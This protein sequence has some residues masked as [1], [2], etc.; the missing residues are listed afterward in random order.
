VILYLCEHFHQKVRQHAV[1][2][3][4]AT[5]HLLTYRTFCSMFTKCSC[6]IAVVLQRL[7][8][9]SQGYIHTS[10]Q[11]AEMAFFVVYYE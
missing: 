5:L 4:V 2:I 3:A 8:V 10:D 11:E 9:N 6:I 7:F 1:F